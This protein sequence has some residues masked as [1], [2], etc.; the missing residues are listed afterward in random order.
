M[1]NFSKTR[2]N[3]KTTEY[4]TPTGFFQPLDD[5]FHFTLDV[6]ATPENNKVA[7][8]FTKEQDGLV[9]PWAGNVCWMNPPYGRDMVKWLAKAKHEADNCGVTTVCLIPSRTNTSWWHS[10]CLKASQIWFVLGRPK[11]DNTSH[12]LPLPLVVVVF[13]PNATQCR[14]GTYYD[15]KN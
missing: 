14:V 15:W 5:I 8:Y 11:F 2:F 7:K 9:Q 6:C 13:E 12:G 10:I 4:S 1:A 3:S